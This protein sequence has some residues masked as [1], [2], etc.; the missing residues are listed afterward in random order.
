M[1]LVMP[2]MTAP[3]VSSSELS[4]ALTNPSNTLNCAIFFPFR[5]DTDPFHFRPG[6]FQRNGCPLGFRPFQVIG[7]GAIAIVLLWF[8]GYSRSKREASGCF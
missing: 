5:S 4:G 7:M 1:L 2:W 3:A 8:G 6:W